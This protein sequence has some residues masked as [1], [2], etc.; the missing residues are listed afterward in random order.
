MPNSLTSTIHPN[1]AS[2]SGRAAK[3]A[4]Q[5]GKYLVVG[6]IAFILDFATLVVCTEWLGFHYL[7]GATVGFLVGL[8]TNY[9]LSVIWVFSERNVSDWKIEFLVFG[10]IG[11]AGLILTGLMMWAGTDILRIDYRICKIA[12][13]VVVTAWNF[14]LRRILL[15]GGTAL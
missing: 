10:V 4:A 6:G 7:A 14:G 13:V 1:V 9:L 5:F 2:P 12:T 3:L 11:V 8:V 15:F